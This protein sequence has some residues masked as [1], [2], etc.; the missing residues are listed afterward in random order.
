MAWLLAAEDASP[1]E[2]RY[3]VNAGFGNWL[4]TAPRA[5]LDWALAQD[6]ALRGVSWFEPVVRRVSRALEWQ[7]AEEALAWAESISRAG[8]RERTQIFILK[9]W[10]A[11]D[12]A[13]ADAWIASST[14]SEAARDEIRSP[15]AADP[16]A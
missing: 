9:R 3:A 14:L 16:E 11:R 7:R 13:G 1:D 15:S 10:R 5:A 8:E 6:P 2:R 12:E 4:R